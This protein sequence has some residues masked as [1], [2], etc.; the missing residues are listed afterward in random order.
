LG[1]A[2][3][4]KGGRRK[5]PKLYTNTKQARP[6]LPSHAEKDQKQ[7]ERKGTPKAWKK[8]S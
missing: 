8:Q 2:K 7:Q 6:A 1:F 5:R 4:E 3:R